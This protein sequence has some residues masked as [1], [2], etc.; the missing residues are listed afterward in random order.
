MLMAVPLGLAEPIS[1]FQETPVPSPAAIFHP[2]PKTPRVPILHGT[3][4]WYSESDPGIN[5]FTANG[6][7]FDDSKWTCASWGFGFGTY[8]RVTNL[9]NGKSVVCRVNDRGPARRL[10]RLIDLTKTAFRQIADTR[11]G[12]V[13]VSVTPV[14]PDAL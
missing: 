9:E 1:L 11:L 14:R 10:S 3:A 6:E 4:S 12:L 13:K 2:L 7:V 5:L 8:L